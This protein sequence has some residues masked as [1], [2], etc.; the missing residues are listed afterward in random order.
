MKPGGP[1][2]RYEHYEE[3]KILAPAENETLENY[4]IVK[5]VYVAYKTQVY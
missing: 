2:S 1:Q 4:K 3:E 5:R